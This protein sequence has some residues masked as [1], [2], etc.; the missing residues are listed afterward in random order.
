MA[1]LRSLALEFYVV[2]AGLAIA[3][4]IAI[5]IHLMALAVA[6]RSQVCEAETRSLLSVVSANES[7]S[8]AVNAAHTMTTGVTASS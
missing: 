2:M 3:I 7:F 1:R 6:I 8:V 5:A 4:A